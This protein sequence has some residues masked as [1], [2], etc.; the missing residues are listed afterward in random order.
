MGV[1]FYGCWNNGASRRQVISYHGIDF[2][3]LKTYLREGRVLTICAISDFKI[4]RKCKYNTTFSNAFGS[5]SDLFIAEF[6]LLFL[7]RARND[8]Y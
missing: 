3:G 2:V 8:A 1:W 4:D 5:Y 7:Y 6:R